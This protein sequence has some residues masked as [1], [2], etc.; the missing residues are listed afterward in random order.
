MKIIHSNKIIDD[1]Q[2]LE[3]FVPNLNF[4][5]KFVDVDLIKINIIIENHIETICV[6][7]FSFIDDIYNKLNKNYDFRL[8]FNNKYIFPGKFTFE[9]NLKN[10]DNIELIKCK[11]NK[12]NLTV[13]LGYKDNRTVIV[14]P[15]EPLYIL[16]EMLNIKDKKM[17]FIY[18]GVT[19]DL[20][21]IFTFEEIGITKEAKITIYYPAI[22][23][24][25]KI[26]LN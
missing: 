24:C 21:T 3:E 19:Y 25:D 26:I 17:K 22:S 4:E 8:K 14:Y 1:N 13:R 16:M 23:G 6:D 5:I 20:A 2:L 7:K 15:E 11:P 18:S 12:I 9:Y 10:G